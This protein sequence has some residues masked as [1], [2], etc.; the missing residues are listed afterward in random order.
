[1]NTVTT[2]ENLYCV[3]DKLSGHIT[4]FFTRSS[5][6]IAVRD[7][8]FTLSYPLKDST[9]LKFGSFECTVPAGEIVANALDCFSNC[10][11]NLQIVPWDSYKLP[12]TKAEALAPLGLSPDE[13]KKLS[14][15][16]I[17]EIESVR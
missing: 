3:F 8:I 15:K 1:M 16:K 14:E 13:V 7:V 9:L 5:D 4:Q 2:K 11:W 6:A 12:E 17:S 10:N